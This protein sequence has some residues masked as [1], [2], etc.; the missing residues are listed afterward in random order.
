MRQLGWAGVYRAHTLISLSTVLTLATLAEGEVSDQGAHRVVL[1]SIAAEPAIIRLRDRLVDRAE[2]ILIIGIL[3]EQSVQPADTSVELVAVGCEE[4]LTE[5]KNRFFDRLLVGGLRDPAVAQE[6]LF[7]DDKF[8]G[9]DLE[10]AEE[11]GFVLLD[12]AQTREAGIGGGLRVWIHVGRLLQ[13]GEDGEKKK[14]S[15]RAWFFYVALG[16]SST[17]Q[18]TC[19]FTWLFALICCKSILHEIIVHM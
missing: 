9:A 13:F 18:I 19:R 5:L 8:V 14:S 17:C 12:W 3:L 4:A 10:C 11:V 2:E 7:E 6:V 1:G 16:R 15:R